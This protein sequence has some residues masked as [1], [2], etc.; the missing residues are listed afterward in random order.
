MLSTLN[1]GTG[2][3]SR[4]F[5]FIFFLSKGFF[6]LIDPDNDTNVDP[7]GRAHTSDWSAQ[8]YNGCL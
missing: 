8:F 5:S 1:T 4:D 3:N 6:T 7:V 2:V